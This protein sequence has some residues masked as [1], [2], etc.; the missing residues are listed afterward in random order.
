MM[1]IHY[2]AILP[3]AKRCSQSAPKKMKHSQ[4]EKEFL[5]MKTV[6]TGSSLLLMEEGG[7][8]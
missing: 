5:S 7:D 4:D 6:M 1:N 2:K 8:R 3:K